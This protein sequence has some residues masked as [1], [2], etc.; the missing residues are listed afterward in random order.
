[1]FSSDKTIDSLAD[2]FKEVKEYFLLQKEY[3]TLDLVEK[4]TILISAISLGFVLM[5]IALLVLFYLSFTLIYLIAPIVGGPTAA[6]AIMTAILAGIGYY[7]YYNREK[8]IIK[9][10]TKGVA[11]ILLSDD[12]PADVIPEEESHEKE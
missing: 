1:M 6:F 9:P 10:I 3:V 4:L 7:L 12:E 5:C 8:L 11:S 2:L